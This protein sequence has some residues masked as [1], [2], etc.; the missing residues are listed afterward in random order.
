MCAAYFYYFAALT[1]ILCN[2]ASPMQLFPATASAA[3]RP[4]RDNCGTTV[5]PALNCQ[6]TRTDLYLLGPPNQSIFTSIHL[7]DNF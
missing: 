7:Q 6:Y 4:S 5:M 2:L 3:R 1:Q